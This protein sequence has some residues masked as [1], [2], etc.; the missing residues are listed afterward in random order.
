[1]KFPT[2]LI[3]YIGNWRSFVSISMFMNFF[4]CSNCSCRGWPDSNVHSCNSKQKLLRWA[5]IPIIN[6]RF[7]TCRPSSR[8]QFKNKRWIILK[9]CWSYD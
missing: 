1:M 5:A 3:L 6:W 9:L 2:T 8:F 7:A 4:S